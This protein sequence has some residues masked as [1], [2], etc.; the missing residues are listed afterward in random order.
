MALSLFTSTWNPHGTWNDH[1]S[2]GG[3]EGYR[4]FLPYALGLA[5]GLGTLALLYAVMSPQSRGDVYRSLDID[6]LNTLPPATEW[7]NVGWWT[8]EPLLTAKGHSAR[9]S[10]DK[11]R[12][13]P[14]FPEACERLAR[15]LYTACGLEPGHG[16]QLKILDVGHGAGESLMLLLR[17]Y[18]PSILRGVTLSSGE[19]ARAQAK[20]LAWKTHASRSD[21]INATD[22]ETT[23]GDAVRYLSTTQVEDCD[24]GYDFI[25][26]LDCA[27]HFQ[28]NRQAFLEAAF[29][30]LKPGGK[31][32][33]FDFCAA[34]PYPN[35]SASWLVSDA[36]LSKPTR[37]AF[38]TAQRF[39]LWV[40][41]LLVSA[42]RANICPLAEYHASLRSIGYQSVVISDVSSHVFPGF[43]NFLQSIGETSWTKGAPWSMRMGLHSF[44]DFVASWAR[45]G[46][47]GLIR[48]ALVVAEKPF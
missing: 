2:D 40:F 25:F 9:P 16:R 45:G 1:G 4:A 48:A 31:I 29:R 5:L 47:E 24:S 7:M 32:G 21:S 19:A 30:S 17:D 23:A 36:H 34:L 33:L 28:P 14:T 15:R 6:I 26:A 22:V 3:Q 42:P 39:K 37:L 35:D 43:S 10:S 20:V 46:N 8:P 13:W 11:C 38:T 27:Y 12:E 18:Q 41:S 44:G